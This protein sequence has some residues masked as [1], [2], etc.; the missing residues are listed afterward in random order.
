[1]VGLP[2]HGESRI[3]TGPDI[4]LKPVRIIGSRRVQYI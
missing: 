4:R 3:S 2:I 1:V